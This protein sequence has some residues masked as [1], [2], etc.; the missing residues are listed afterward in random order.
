[1]DGIVKNVTLAVLIILAIG[2]AILLR[3]TRNDFEAR[4][5]AARHVIDSL[6]RESRALSVILDARTKTLDSL[7][8]AR[9]IHPHTII[10]DGSVQGLQS[11]IDKRFPR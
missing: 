7:A 8:R 5:R 9:N 4:D 6:T 10:L 2:V 11:E 1:M 3:S